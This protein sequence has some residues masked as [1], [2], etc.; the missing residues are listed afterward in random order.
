MEACG[1]WG[2]WGVEACGAWGCVGLGSAQRRP[3]GGAAGGEETYQM[4]GGATGARA[5]R[6]REAPRVGVCPG[7]AR[8]GR[9]E[10]PRV[11]ETLATDDSMAVSLSM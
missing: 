9:E 4:Q 5:M 7:H 2:A 11:R 1:V 6:A 8:Y 3:M 10:T